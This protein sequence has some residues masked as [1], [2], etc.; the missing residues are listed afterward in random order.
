MHVTMLIKAKMVH[1]FWRPELPRTPSPSLADSITRQQSAD[2]PSSSQESSIVVV[3][4]PSS[5][6]IRDIRA[7][8]RAHSTPPWPDQPLGKE[9]ENRRPP[10]MMFGRI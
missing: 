6:D 9:S 1:L 2:F 5:G 3:R 7:R 4:R 8:R 10:F